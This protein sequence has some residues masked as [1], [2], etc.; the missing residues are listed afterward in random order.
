MSDI[1]L[2]R[3]PFCGIDVRLVWNG[4]YAA[5]LIRHLRPS[6]GCIMEQRVFFGMSDE[7]AASLWNRRPDTEEEK[8]D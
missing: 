2:K 8:D 7:K 4:Y 5:P 6:G 1:K 3:C